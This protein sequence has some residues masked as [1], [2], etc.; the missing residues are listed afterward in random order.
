M[1]SRTS[2]ITSV[3]IVVIVFGSVGGILL[4]TNPYEPSRVAVVVMEPGFGDL[5]Y[6]DQLYKGLMELSGDISVQ[7]I[8]P[9]Y[10]ST[11]AEA[12]S[13]LEQLAASGQYVLIIAVGF[14]MVSSVSAIANEYPNQQ[15][16]II[17]GYVD[18]PNVVSTTFKVEQASFLA[19]VLAAFVA[20]NETG[21]IGIMG[22]IETD[23]DV[24]DMI[25]GFIQGVKEA[26]ATHNLNVELLDPLYIGSYNNTELATTYT[27]SLFISQQASIIFAPVR[28]SMKGVRIGMDIANRTFLYLQDRK[29]LVIAAGGDQDYLGNPDPAIAVGPSWIPIS[30]VPHTDIAAYQI[31]NATLWGDFPGGEH[32]VYDLANGGVNI[33]DFTFSNTYISPEIRN[34]VWSYYDDIVNGVI[35]VDT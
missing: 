35:T 23:P 16:A 30:V 34:I 27:T 28:A 29:P 3:I 21:R 26:N 13:T 18:A 5:S 8:F 32:Y 7:Y 12:Q 14:Q 20:N 17:D 22:S 1:S 6:A 19:G 2:I 4:L 11:A 15:F 25:D 9:D 24:A 31:L 33:T 10:P